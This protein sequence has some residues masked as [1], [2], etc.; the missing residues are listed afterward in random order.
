MFKVNK[1]NPKTA[2]LMSSQSSVFFVNFERNFTTF[3][4]VCIVDLCACT[5][6]SPDSY[7]L[8]LCE[9]EMGLNSLGK[10]SV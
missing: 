2:S 4:N 1:K 8:S 7:R 6:S 9:K 10:A 5:H 3:P